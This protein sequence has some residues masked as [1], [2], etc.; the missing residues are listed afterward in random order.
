MSVAWPPMTRQSTEAMS[1]EAHAFLGN[2]FSTRSDLP[3]V[4]K[5][6][7]QSKPKGAFSHRILVISRFRVLTLK[8]STLGMKLKLSKDFSFIELLKM[9]VE[10]AESTTALKL[11]FSNGRILH[12]DPGVHCEDIVRTIQ[13]CVDKIAAVFPPTGRPKVIIPPVLAWE[14]YCPDASEADRVIDAMISFRHES[15]ACCDFYQLVAMPQVAEALKVSLGSAVLDVKQCLEGVSENVRDAHALALVHAVRYTPHFDSI[16]LHGLSVGDFGFSMLFEALEHSP[17]L[18]SIQLSQVHLSRA[19]LLA[20]EE[21]ARTKQG[22]HPEFDWPLTALDLSYN[23]LTKDAASVLASA[24]AHLPSALQVP[25]ILVRL[26]TSAADARRGPLRPLTPPPCA[27]F[28]CDPTTHG[29][30]HSL[31]TPLSTSLQWTTTLRALDLSFNPFEHEVR[32][33]ICPCFTRRFAGNNRTLGVDFRGRD[34]PAPQPCSSSRVTSSC[35]PQ[36]GTGVDTTTFLGA[37]KLNTALKLQ[38]VDLSHNAFKADAG[39]ILGEILGS[40]YTLAS[41]HLRGIRPT[42]TVLDAI[43][44]PWFQNPRLQATPLSLDLSDNDLSGAAGLHMA[45]LLQQSL[46]T[47]RHALKL[48]HCN[49]RDDALEAIVSAL[50][51]CVSLRT[52][53]L[54]GNG[55]APPKRSIFLFSASLPQTPSDAFVKLLTKQHHL[56]ELYLSNDS[57]AYPMGLLRPVLNSLGAATS[58]LEV[59]DIS[60]NRGGD[61][62]AKCLAAVLPKT[63]CLRALYW[64]GNGTTVAGFRIFQEALRRNRSLLVMPVPIQDTRRLLDRRDPHRDALFSILS[65]L[66][67]SFHETHSS[68]VRIDEFLE[69]NQAEASSRHGV[70]VASSLVFRAANNCDVG[71]SVALSIDHADLPRW[72]PIDMR[73][74]WSAEISALSAVTYATT[75]D[76]NAAHEG[77]DIPWG[78]INT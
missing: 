51:Q 29:I 8:S 24:L 42:K 23:R 41:L 25:P 57:R 39:V 76:N 31:P 6:V 3:L 40:T 22:H 12:V 70:A 68:T 59:L 2:L 72:T 9:Q 32:P 19:G 69:R 18:S 33:R 52:L 54:D 13:R 20:L 10:Q 16:V 50:G 46:S 66:C 49:I 37:L 30:K 44:A 5:W 55:G 47:P 43:L 61:D 27:Y 65:T 34:T 48:N 26:L 73:K 4:A 28:N 17:K 56:E 75:V 38:S 62:V 60:G 78:A 63:S 45:A 36:A 53:H 1:E 67:T 77:D 35:A 7:V 64:D 71:R 11:I 74:S 15:S 14:E 21:A 58:T